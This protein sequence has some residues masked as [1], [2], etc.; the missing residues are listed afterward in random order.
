MGSIDMGVTHLY[1][2]YIL[3]QATIHALS[4]ICLH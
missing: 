4:C 2:M 3:Y 1:E